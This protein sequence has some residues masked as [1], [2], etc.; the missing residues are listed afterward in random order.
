MRL[1]GFFAEL[2]FSAGSAIKE[3]DNHLEKELFRCWDAWLDEFLKVVP[4]W[5]GESVG[6]VLPLARVIGRSI[7]IVPASSAPADRS[8]A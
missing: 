8:A 3:I 6:S 2:N 1:T 7:P 5:T 4:V